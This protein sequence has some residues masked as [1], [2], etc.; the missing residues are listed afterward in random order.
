MLLYQYESYNMV[1]SRGKLSSVDKFIIQISFTH[2]D[3]QILISISTRLEKNAGLD[4]ELV[5]I[6]LLVVFLC[7]RF[8][9]RDSSV[10]NW[11]VIVIN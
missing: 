5:L 3:H 7:C 6:N 8:A 11:F 1:G 2:E 9:F 4:N 10:S